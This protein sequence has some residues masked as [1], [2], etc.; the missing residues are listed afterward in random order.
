MTSDASGSLLES[1]AASWCLRAVWFKPK[2]I[3]KK[4]VQSLAARYT[5]PRGL[6]LASRVPALVFTSLRGQRR[7]RRRVFVADRCSS[8]TAEGSCNMRD[9]RES[10]D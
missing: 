6:W 9:T 2:H 7:A 10:C 1:S 3:D 8:K 4:C 5:L